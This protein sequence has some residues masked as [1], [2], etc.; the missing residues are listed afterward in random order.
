ML[1]MSSFFAF[2]AA[3]VLQYRYFVTLTTSIRRGKRLA[4]L[5]KFAFTAGGATFASVV[6]VWA[7]SLPANFS[8]SGLP[9]RPTPTTAA[10]N[11]PAS[12]A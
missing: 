3:R 12:R 6:G 11:A 4:A 5:A 8:Y 1:T 10:M 9:N 7:E 2:P